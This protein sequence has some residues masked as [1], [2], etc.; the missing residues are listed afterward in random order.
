MERQNGVLDTVESRRGLGPS[1]MRRKGIIRPQQEETQELAHV[2]DMGVKHE[3][4]KSF[5][6]LYGQCW[7]LEDIDIVSRRIKNTKSRYP[8]AL[9]V[10]GGELPPAAQSEMR[11]RHNEMMR[12]GV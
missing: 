5:A 3:Q 4:D 12:L 6:Y 8:S 1:K 10:L 11:R 7:N 9:E 2:P